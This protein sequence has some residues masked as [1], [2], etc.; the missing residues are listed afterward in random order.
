MIQPASEALPPA[1]QTD[2]RALQDFA[3]ASLL[4]RAEGDGVVGLLVGVARPERGAA[5]LVVRV[6]VRMRAGLLYK[7]AIA[8]G[9]SA[10]HVV[11]AEK[12]TY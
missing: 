5:R 2:G 3:H 6:H 1:V 8:E 12:N 9:L 10:P 11:E 4:S 7:Y